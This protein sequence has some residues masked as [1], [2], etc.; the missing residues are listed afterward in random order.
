MRLE[1][2]RPGTCVVFLVKL[3]QS[4]I[5]SW[6]ADSAGWGGESICVRHRGG[7]VEPATTTFIFIFDSTYCPVYSVDPSWFWVHCWIWSNKDILCGLLI[8]CGNEIVI[9][10]LKGDM[11]YIPTKT[12]FVLSTLCSAVLSSVMYSTTYVHSSTFRLAE[13]TTRGPLECG[14]C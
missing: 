13:P 7:M 8:V 2:T 1:S 6:T 12:I 10:S 4:E 5:G 14:C 9:H 11:V 3:C